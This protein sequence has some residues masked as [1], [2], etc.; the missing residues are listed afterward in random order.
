MKYTYTFIL[1]CCF[2]V[3]TSAQSLTDEILTG[4]WK[5]TEVV[6][7]TDE[8]PEEEIKFMQEMTEAFK[9]STFHFSPDNGFNLEISIGE[10]AANLKDLFWKINTSKDKILLQETANDTSEDAPF[11]I[12]TTEIDGQYTFELSR[13]PFKMTVKKDAN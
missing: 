8:I 13:M 9:T 11:V 5:V 3:I 2:T 6:T 12:S 7:T 1:A 10:L 4:N